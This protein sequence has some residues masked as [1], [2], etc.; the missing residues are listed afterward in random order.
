MQRTTGAKL[1][2][3][4]LILRSLHIKQLNTVLRVIMPFAIDPG[5][6]Y[7][8][9]YYVNLYYNLIVIV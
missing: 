9:P 6:L 2:T 3:G 4:L 1:L 7:L 5:T 8:I